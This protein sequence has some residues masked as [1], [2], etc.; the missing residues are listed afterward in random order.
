MEERWMMIQFE[1]EGGRVLCESI[2]GKKINLGI[3][4]S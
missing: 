3:L 1:E 2:W 4:Q